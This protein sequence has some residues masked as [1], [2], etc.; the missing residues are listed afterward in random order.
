MR[1]HSVRVLGILLCL[2]VLEGLSWSAQAAD[3]SSAPF[4]EASEAYGQGDF[5]GASRLFLETITQNGYSAGICNNLAAVYAQMGKTGL[6]VVNYQRAAFLAPAD[7]EIQA[8]LHSLQKQAG[9]FPSESKAIKLLAFSLSQQQWSSV[10]LI[11]LAACALAITCFYREVLSHRLFYG[12]VLVAVLMIGCSVAALITQQHR[13]QAAVVIAADTHLL[14]SPFTGA[15][16]V[17]Q[18]D[19]GRLVY[20]ER[21]HAEFVAVID[22][23]GKKGWLPKA[24]IEKIL[25]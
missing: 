20:I 1:K 23:A 24:A 6:A 7:P 17:A 15:G 13:W 2:L 19:E 5:A 9:I 10:L 11:G 22:D 12:S 4:R 16:S 21:K 25:P 3:D 14:I 18:I 8:N